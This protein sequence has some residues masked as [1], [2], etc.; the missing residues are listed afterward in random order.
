MTVFGSWVFGEVTTSRV[1]LSKVTLPRILF[2]GTFY[3][4]LPAEV[5]FYLTLLKLMLLAL[6][7]L[8]RCCSTSCTTV[9]DEPESGTKKSILIVFELVLELVDEAELDDCN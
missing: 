1:V 6:L 3:C 4:N 8:A 9:A 5:S 7:L 2:A